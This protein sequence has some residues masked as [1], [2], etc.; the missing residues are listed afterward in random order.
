MTATDDRIAAERAVVRGE[1]P[2][3]PEQP[4]ATVKLNSTL[5]GALAGH[6][7]TMS[8]LAA[9]AMVSVGLALEER[10]HVLDHAWCTNTYL[11][12]HPSIDR[13]MRT[14]PPKRAQPRKGAGS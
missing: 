2:A 4:L 1:R 7:N 8:R 6:G 12:L 5:R 3:L 11:M 14:A 10:G 9:A 13:A